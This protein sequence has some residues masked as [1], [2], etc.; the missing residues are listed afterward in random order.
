MMKNIFFI[1]IIL[2]TI[3]G[4]RKNFSRENLN[5]K[6]I[7]Y[8]NKSNVVYNKVV[9][10]SD[11]D[12]VYFFYNNGALFKKG[13][14]FKKNQK[15]GN[16]ELF[17]KNGNLR[18]IREWFTISG[19]TRINR[20]WYLN[21]KGDT[22]AYKRED[23]IFKQKE[24]INDTISILGS[25][26]NTFKFITN[27][28]IYINENYYGF[29]N[30]GSPV[31]RD[32]NS[33]IIVVVDNKNTLKKDF[34]NINE[35]KLDTFYYAKIDTVHKTKFPNFDLDKVAAFSGK[36]DNSGEKIIRGIM[37]EYTNEYP[38]KDNEKVRAESLTYFEKKIFVKEGKQ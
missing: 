23:S 37:I 27:D 31:L 2:F 8:P 33:K 7:Y 10:K 16:W 29:A 38:I 3:Y 9:H 25:N 21:Q 13:K 32:Y 19:K 12:S 6:I 17:D 14:R 11:F 20:I 30:L 4:C 15:F 35:V 24:F 36:F 22:L 26:W 34:S 18:E 5:E 1:L 28:T